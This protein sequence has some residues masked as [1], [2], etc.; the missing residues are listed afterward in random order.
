M[1]GNSLCYN[2]H[3]LDRTGLAGARIHRSWFFGAKG[4]GGGGNTTGATRGAKVQSVAT[5]SQLF[6]GWMLFP[7]AH[8]TV[9]E[10]RKETE[11]EP[12]RI[13]SN[14]AVVCYRID[15]AGHLVNRFGITERAWHR[16]K[17]NIDSK[18]RTAFRRKMRGQ[19][20]TVKAFRGKVASTYVQVGQP[21]RVE[22]DED[23]NSMPGTTDS[24][25]QINEV[26]TEN[27]I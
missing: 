26:C 20:L 2:G 9:S 7:V 16:I 17:L 25:L 10:H 4:K 24:V 6:T 11:W 22:S 27:L 18:C 14:F 12:G 13:C 8:P 5:N 19:P 23:T 15:A 1:N 21:I 3:F